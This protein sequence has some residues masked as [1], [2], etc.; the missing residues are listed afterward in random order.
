M[1]FKRLLF[2]ALFLLL[3]TTLSIGQ[4]KQLAK[5]DFVKLDFKTLATNKIRLQNNDGNL[6]PAYLR[7]ISEADAY[8]T[9]KPVSVMGKKELPPSGDKHDYMSLAPYWWP[10]VSKPDGL[11]YIR[12]DGEVNPE[13]HNYPD[14][15]S[16]PKMCEAVYKLSL[17]YYFSNNEKYAVHANKLIE[18]W[19]LDSATKMN[20][21]LNYGQAVKG[22][23]DGR[24][25]GIIDTRI[26]I[27]L[28][29]GAQLLQNSKA[30]T[31]ENQTSLKKWFADFSTWLQ[32]S[33]IGKDERDA[34]NNHGVWYDAQT[35]SYAVFANNNT[36]A[37]KIILR[38]A[39][40]LDV[41]MDSNG[42][43]P[44][45][46]ARTTS[47]HYSV[48]ILNAFF[49]IAQLSEQVKNPFWTLK[50][51]SGKSIQKGFD[52]ILPFIIK[53]K[54]WPKKDVHDFNYGDGEPLLLYGS[55]NFN[56][57]KCLPAV[58]KNKSNALSNL[59]F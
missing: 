16:M 29:D 49:T 11:P 41:Q 45:E 19:F 7:L 25:E 20:A 56:C 27:Y 4:S 55:Q 13:I 35:L 3:L 30:Y 23:V 53:E 44:F 50:T 48:F 2:N 15:E 42:F 51:T 52:A 37:N 47:L 58:E 57:N 8:L 22:V 9:F 1:I 26:F 43:F 12:K 6:K 31:K 34:K 38:A 14:K 28:I 5:S 39:D 21:N 18:V 10:N 36:M 17:A 40:R 32:T 59:L 33:D 24:A 46:V 54:V